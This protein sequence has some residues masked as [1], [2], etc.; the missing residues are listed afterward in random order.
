M[1]KYKVRYFHIKMKM[2]ESRDVL[3]KEHSTKEV[4]KCKGPGGHSIAFSLLACS[5]QLFYGLWLL[6][7][8]VT[9]SFFLSSVPTFFLPSF[10]LF[11]D[12]SII[13]T[14]RGLLRKSYGHEDITP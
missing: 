9:P 14:V 7:R 11:H 2:D 5:V 6:L 13:Y 12:L 10:L 8:Q 3:S 1:E 4:S